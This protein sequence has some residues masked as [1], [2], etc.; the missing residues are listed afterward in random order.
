MEIDAFQTRMMLF[1]LGESF[2]AYGRK[3]FIGPEPFRPKK[4]T[5]SR[6]RKK[7]TRFFENFFSI[8]FDGVFVHATGSPP[9]YLQREER[10][11][12]FFRKIFQCVI[13]VETHYFVITSVERD[14]AHKAEVFWRKTT[15]NYSSCNETAKLFFYY[16][17]L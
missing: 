7:N 13:T 8:I 15:F 5:E 9:V 16:S 6:T 11:I 10:R 17:I 3:F 2:S 14:E 4:F 12:L 1:L